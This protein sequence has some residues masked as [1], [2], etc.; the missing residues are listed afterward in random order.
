[1]EKNKDKKEKNQDKSQYQ[2]QSQHLEILEWPKAI[3][4]GMTNSIINIVR[5]GE[6]FYNDDQAQTASFIRKNLTEQ[7]NG[8]WTVIICPKSSKD[9]DVSFTTAL[10]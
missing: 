5:N 7:F 8:L 2:S 1:M 4:T 9:V 10:N 6:Q 3:A